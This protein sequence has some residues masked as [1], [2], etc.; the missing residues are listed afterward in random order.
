LIPVVIFA[1][2]RPAHISDLL[3]SLS[4]NPEA[5]ATQLFIYLDGPRNDDDKTKLSEVSKN[6]SKFNTHFGQI[7]VIKRQRNCG[8]ALNIVTGINEQFKTYDAL[9]ILE[10]DLIVSKKFL[11]Y[12]NTALTNYE[13][14]KQVFHI[15]AYSDFHTTSPIVTCHFSSGMNCWG[16]GTWR[17]RWLYFDNQNIDITMNSIFPRRSKFN[18]DRSHDFFLQLVEN[19][20][21]IMNT[22]AIFWYAAIFLQSGLSLNPSLPFAINRGNDGTGERHGNS[23]SNDDA[24][25][26]VEQQVIKFPNLV[27]FD[28]LFYNKQ[29]NFY[30]SRKSLIS[31]IIKMVIYKIIPIKYRKN[32]TQKLITI[33][34]RFF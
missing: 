1:F 17:D 32:I 11:S 19:K 31:E 9:I 4:L 26:L 14:E 23:T 13:N 27:Q 21:G 8:S 22:W 15:S 24:R 28:M 3:S 10:D 16:W 34:Q 5:S 18:F 12:M 6:I 33:R 7:N 30:R 25:Y 2:N 29:V 20:H